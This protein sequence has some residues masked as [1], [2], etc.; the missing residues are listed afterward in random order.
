MGH[1]AIGCLGVA[2]SGPASDR[3]TNVA[4]MEPVE[5]GP[6]LPPH[7]AEVLDVAARCEETKVAAGVVG[8]PEIAFLGEG[9]RRFLLAA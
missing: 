5:F 6:E 9:T 1:V 7:R 8:Q 4:M 2:P 3:G